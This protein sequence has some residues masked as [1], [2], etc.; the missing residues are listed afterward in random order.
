MRSEMTMTRRATAGRKSRRGKMGR[1]GLGVKRGE[2]LVRGRVRVRVRVRRGKVYETC[3]RDVNTTTILLLT[4]GG[5][6][7][8]LTQLEMTMDGYC[9]ISCD[10]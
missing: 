6:V 10:D 7:H 3:L 9:M 2:L 8:A 5:C 4:G 1:M